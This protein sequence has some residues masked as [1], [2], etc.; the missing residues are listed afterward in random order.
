MIAVGCLC[1]QLI[2]LFFVVR[3]MWVLKK[4]ITIGEAVRT[5]NYDLIHNN[6]LID[7]DM[8]DRIYSY[9]YVMLS[10]WKWHASQFMPKEDYEKIE[11]YISK[12][13]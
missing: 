9:N 1:I 8:Y 13:Y 4:F 10:F 11:P 2:C 7:L 3:N 12:S 5:Y 6:K